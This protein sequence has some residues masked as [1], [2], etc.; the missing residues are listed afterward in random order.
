MQ[1]YGILFDRSLTLG[2]RMHDRVSDILSRHYLLVKRLLL[3]GSYLVLLAFFLP[4]AAS[5][6]RDF[7]EMAGNL[8]IVI[9]FLSPLSVLFRMPLLLLL[10]GLRR[11]L[12]IL[13]GCLALVHGVWYFVTPSFFWE[14]GQSL[15]RVSGFVW[16]KGIGA[17]IIGLALILPLLLTSNTFS[18]RL[19]GGK[20]WKRLHRLAYPAFFFIVFHRFFMGESWQSPVPFVEAVLLL[21]TYTMM[22]FLAWRPTAFPWLQE[23]IGEV[24]VRYRQYR[25][26]RV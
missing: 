6:Q 8:L 4:T 24:G 26:E 7:G 20:L 12:G 17:G 9:L 14:T 16:E 19:L 13:M 5:F 23:G 10:M 21:G 18:V 1:E 22:K 2:F 25:M 11:E 3:A 15:L